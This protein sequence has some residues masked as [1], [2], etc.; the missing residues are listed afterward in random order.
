[1]RLP[2]FEPWLRLEQT[3]PSRCL[4]VRPLIMAALTFRGLIPAM[5][6]I[7]RDRRDR[8]VFFRLM[9]TT[10]PDDVTPKTP[11]DEEATF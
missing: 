10:S 2:S 5:S 8:Y 11:E 9:H 3:P 6:G 4:M 1:M 7:G